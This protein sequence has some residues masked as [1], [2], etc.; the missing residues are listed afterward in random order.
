MENKDTNLKYKIEGNLTEVHGTYRDLL[1]DIELFRKEGFKSNRNRDEFSRFT[2]N[3]DSEHKGFSGGTWEDVTNL[4]NMEDF[5]RVLADFKKNKLE[6]KVITKLDYSPK[7][8]RKMCEHDGD[9]DHQRRWEIRPFV[10]SRREMAPI[11]VVDVNV[12]FSISCGMGA[13]AINKYGALVWSIIQLVE[14]LGIQC[15]IKVI[16]ESEGSTS[17]GKNSKL[18]YTLKKAGEYISPVA[19]ATCFQSVFYRRAIFAGIVMQAEMSGKKVAIGLGRPKHMKSDKYIWFK[20]GAI[21]T[22]PGGMFNEKE[23]IEA[24]LTMVGKK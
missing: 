6:E 21:Y 17:C 20:D 22:R 19:L 24:I 14:S 23:I 13:E 8:K 18:V 7:R 15:N 16:N 12:D 9:Y 4:E 10:N 11:T 5:K 3:K 2:T 1:K